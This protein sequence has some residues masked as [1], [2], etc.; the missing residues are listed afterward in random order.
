M[1]EVEGIINASSASTPI[2]TITREEDPDVTITRISKGGNLV[3]EGS[4]DG[5][6][7]KGLRTKRNPTQTTT[8]TTTNSNKTAKVRLMTGKE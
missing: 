5:R 2:H 6:T 8:R 3:D 4:K 1:E 7:R